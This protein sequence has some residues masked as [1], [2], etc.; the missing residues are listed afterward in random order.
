[1]DGKQRE[2]GWQWWTLKSWNDFSIDNNLLMEEEY[3]ISLFEK[4]DQVLEEIKRFEEGLKKKLSLS[5]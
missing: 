1:M 4:L 5:L 3:R 2:P